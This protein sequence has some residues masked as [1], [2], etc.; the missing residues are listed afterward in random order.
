MNK[1]RGDLKKKT[2]LGGDDDHQYDPPVNGDP[3]NF[4]AP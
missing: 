1:Q 4:P 2:T 3:E